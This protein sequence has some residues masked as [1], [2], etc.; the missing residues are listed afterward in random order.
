MA[1]ALAQPH[2]KLKTCHMLNDGGICAFIVFGDLSSQMMFPADA[3]SKP[4]CT[5]WHH[6]AS[7]N[8]VSWR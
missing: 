8:D 4:A 2:I 1:T 5:P 6:N 3:F 7:I